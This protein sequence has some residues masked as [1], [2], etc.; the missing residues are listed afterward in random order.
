MKFKTFRHRLRTCVRKAQLEGWQLSP[1]VHRLDRKQ[2]R[3]NPLCMIGIDK[4]WETFLEVA[5]NI[6]LGERQRDA[7]VDGFDVGYSRD[8]AKH[9]KDV[10]LFYQLGYRYREGYV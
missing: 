9:Y 10:R 1:D 6:R 5:E 3:G 8:L 7:F 2:K 4:S